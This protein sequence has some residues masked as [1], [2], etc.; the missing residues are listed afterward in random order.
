MLAIS[1]GLVKNSF[2]ASFAWRVA[3][4]TSDDLPT[5]LAAAHALFDGSGVSLDQPTRAFLSSPKGLSLV[6]EA[7]SSIC[8]RG[9][10]VAHPATVPRTH[11]D[12]PVSCNPVPLEARGLQALVDFV[13]A[14]YVYH[15]LLSAQV[16]TVSL[17]GSYI[18][19]VIGTGYPR[20]FCIY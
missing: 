14:Q 5:R 11:F 1:A 7:K 20:V 19:A 16:L 17:G 4:G 12:G 2:G 6:V 15:I 10:R 9:D 3:L 8:L 13:C 18:F